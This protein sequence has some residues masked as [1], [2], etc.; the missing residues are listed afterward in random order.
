MIF[1][2]EIKDDLENIKYYSIRKYLLDSYFK[3]FANNDISALT[4]KYNKAME[5]APIKLYH[6]YVLRYLKDYT[7]EDVANEMGFTHTTI[8]SMHQSLIQ[9]LSKNIKKDN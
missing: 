7:L 4:Q 3:E 1:E 9:W 5:S 8:H 2:N 6:L